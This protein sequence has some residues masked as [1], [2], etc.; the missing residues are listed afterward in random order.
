M[1]IRLLFITLLSFSLF[2]CG[3]DPCE[4]DANSL[5]CPTGDFDGDGV[6]NQDDTAPEDSCVPNLPVFSQN[7]VG[8]W[9]YSTGFSTGQVK[10]N[11]DGSYEDQVNELIS[12]GPIIS[13][14]W[15]IEDQTVKFDVENAALYLTWTVYDC[16][17]ITFKLDDITIVF[18]RI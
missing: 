10:I 16:N 2:S 15:S 14:S 13:S 11:S 5:D 4:L 9:A 3:D 6:S 1:L 12:N 17:S 8:T 7:F 18:T